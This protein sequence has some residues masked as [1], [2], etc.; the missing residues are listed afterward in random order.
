MFSKIWGK[1]ANREA[2]SYLIF[3]VLTTLVDWL[4]YAL[5][6]AV[7]TDY[8]VSTALSWAVAVLFAFVT[9]KLIVFRSFNLS[10]GFL[11][12]EFSTFVTARLATGLFTMVAMIVMVDWLHWHEFVGKFM[13][14]VI[15]MVLNYVLSKLFIFKKE[16]SGEK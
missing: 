5:L 3:G 1:L 8:R 11:W 16:K 2:V 7:G 14:S 4:T 10:P 9:N 6:Y 15:S 12:R 13:V